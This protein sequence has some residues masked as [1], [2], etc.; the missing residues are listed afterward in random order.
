MPSWPAKSGEKFK[1]RKIQDGNVVAVLLAGGRR[2][3]KDVK[4][5]RVR[6]SF[7]GRRRGQKARKRRGFLRLF[8]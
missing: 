1:S 5:K 8:W 6:E 7:A 3:G 2:L 4:S